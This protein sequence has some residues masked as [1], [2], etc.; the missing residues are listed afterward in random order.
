VATDNSSPANTAVAAPIQVTVRRNN[1]IQDD[2]SFILQSYSDIAN[3]TTINPLVLAD[4]ADQLAAGTLAR[5]KIVTDLMTQPGFVAP[6]N[7]LATYWVLMGQWPTPTNYTALLTTTRNAGLPAAVNSILSSNEYF[8]EIRRPAH[9]RRPQQ[10]DE[11]PPGRYL[12]RQPLAC[13]RSC[14][15]QCAP[16]ESGQFRSNNVRSLPTFGRGYNSGRPPERARRI[17]HQHQFRQHRPLRQ[18][19]RSRVV[20]PAQPPALSARYDGQGNYRRDR[21]PRR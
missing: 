19:P 8:P 20:L 18:G 15:R 21:C 1:P 17:H 2:T 5:T 11:R 12:H 14:Q 10:P 13:G 4:L 9:G 7:L 6:I 16:S 3:T